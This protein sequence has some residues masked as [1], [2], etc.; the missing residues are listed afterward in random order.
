[1]ETPRPAS[2][3]LAQQDLEIIEDILHG[4][5]ARFDEL[6]SRYYRRLYQIAFGV[7]ANA[8]DAEE[9]VQDSFVKAFKHLPN[10]RSTSTFYTWIRQIVLNAA[11]DKYQWLRRRGRQQTVSISDLGFATDDSEHKEDYQVPSEALSPERMFSMDETRRNIED[12]FQ[13]L[14]DAMREVMTLRH[15]EDMTYEEIA[16]HLECNLGTVKSRLARGREFL[17]ECIQL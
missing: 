6:V 11:R 17:H 2:Q 7:I 5:E 1:M 16:E 13:K 15:L 9:V 3:E 10:F 4:N 14:P 12:C 8:E